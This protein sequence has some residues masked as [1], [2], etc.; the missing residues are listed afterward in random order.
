MSFIKACKYNTGLLLDP[1]KDWHRTMLDDFNMVNESRSQG[2]P[3][4]FFL[5]LHILVTGD[6]KD[7]CLQN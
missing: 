4:T 5:V 1:S 7:V 3:L 6:H 2:N